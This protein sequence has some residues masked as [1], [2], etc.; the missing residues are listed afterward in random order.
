M[1]RDDRVET[2][3]TA[4]TVLTEAPRHALLIRIP[5]HLPPAYNLCIIFSPDYQAEGSNSLADWLVRFPG[6]L[7]SK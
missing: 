6:F 2:A 4:Q 5:L 1:L 3:I 7:N